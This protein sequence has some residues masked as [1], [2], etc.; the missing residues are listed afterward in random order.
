[1]KPLIAALWVATLGAA[2]GLGHRFAAESL[3]RARVE[4]HGEMP[5]RLSDAL[6]D[7]D[8][9][10]RTYRLAEALQ[11]LDDRDIDAAVAVL[12]AQRL[13]VTEGEVRLFMLAWCRFDPAGAFAWADAWP[14]PWRSTLVRTAIFA[15]GVRDPEGAVQ[16]FG[17]LETARR[18]E[19]RASLISGWARSDDRAGLTEFLFSRPAGPER[20]RYLGVLLA[21]LL[22]DGPEAI[23]SWAEAVPVDAPHQARVTA[24][25]TA[26][27]ALAQKD[28]SDAT[29]LIE[30]HQQFE[31]AQPA[32]KPIARRWVDHHDPQ[33]LFDWL[34][35]LPA[36]EGRAEAVEAGFSRWWSKAP[37]DAGAWLRAAPK[38]E[39]L[40][41]AVAVYARHLSRTSAEQA[42]EW[43][44]GIH[45]EALRRRTLAPILRLWSREDP[46]AARAWM[47]GQHLPRELQQEL[48]NPPP[49]LLETL[50]SQSQRSDPGGRGRGLPAVGL[51]E[52]ADFDARPLR[53]GALRTDDGIECLARARRFALGGE[54]EAEVVARTRSLRL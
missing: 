1:V 15:W 41:P 6:R 30:A 24:F 2:W 49:A 25:M 32:L 33:G 38:S 10:T 23:R 31:Y 11:E 42:V 46:S 47:D 35:S 43:A 34:L 19:L 26:G 36:N 29:A 17:G 50:P 48:L 8:V 44:E 28:P 12:E 40:D 7:R 4:I 39:A 37:Q 53:L 22:Q 13:G 18:E 5:A 16:A 3:S 51:V 45:D 21:E 27:G 9:L 54:G 14:G 52:A 20:S